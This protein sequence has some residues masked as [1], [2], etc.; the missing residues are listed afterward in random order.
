MVTRRLRIAFL[1][2]ILSHTG[3]IKG[4]IKLT[5]L[6][7]KIHQSLVRDI[8]RDHEGYLWIA[9]NG[10][11]L[12]KHDSHAITRYLHSEDDSTSMSNNGIMAIEEDSL[13]NLWIGTISGLNRYQRKKDNFNRYFN[14][15]GDTTSLSSNYINELYI[16][17]KGTLW[18]LTTNGL[19]KYLPESDTFQPYFIQNSYLS[20]NF[21]GMDQDQNGMYWVVT[22]SNGIYQFLPEKNQFIHFPDNQTDPGRFYSKKILIDSKN[23][24]WIANWGTGLSKYNPDSLNFK[25]WPINENG[26]GT[27]KRLIMDILEWKDNQILLAVDQGG[28]NILDL[29]TNI[30]SYI[31]TNAPQHGTLTSNGVYCFHHDKEDI[32]WVGTSRGGV[33]YYNPKENMFNTFTNKGVN[34]NLRE[35]NF[36]FPI[37]NIIPCFFED[38]EGQIWIG[39]DGGG[40]AQFNRK[41]QK[42]RF[43]LH[44]SNNPH[45][46][47]SNVIR[48]ITEDAKGN[49]YIA[50]WDGGINKFDKNTGR[51]TVENFKRLSDGGYHGENLWK[52]ANDSRNRF[53]ITNPVGQIDL[54][55]ENKKLL[56]Q[57]FMEPNPEIYHLPVIFED[58]QKQIYVNTVNGVFE[59]QEEG[60]FFNKII[61]IPEVTFVNVDDPQY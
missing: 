61:S 1:I 13:N 58:H 22:T 56:G 14:A 48:G 32:L 28:I 16:D 47:S 57:F 33:N 6:P 29:E 19:C 41:T 4:Q 44:D 39:T 15:P 38:S 23:N 12:M 10:V 37:F 55:N 35:G 27:N 24:F 52:I 11:G 40:L 45:S 2:L 42:F 36:N 3:L 50:T 46:I 30:I 26:T 51:F 53:W 60:K 54:Y 43:F 49:I 5:P 7:S 17:D 59:F 21:T 18:V 20:N 8:H 31:K 9:N 25:Y 34:I